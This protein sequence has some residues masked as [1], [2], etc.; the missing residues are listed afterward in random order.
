VFFYQW[1]IS[2]RILHVKH[3]RAR[4]CIPFTWLTGCF[5][6][7]IN[8]PTFFLTEMASQY[9]STQPI[10]NISMTIHPQMALKR[11]R[12]CAITRLEKIRNRRE[13]L[14]PASR[15]FLLWFILR[16]CR[17]RRHVPP[18]CRLTS[19]GLLGIVSR[20]MKFFLSPYSLSLTWIWTGTLRM[21]ARPFTALVIW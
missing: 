20:K 16:P 6:L 8:R 1:S 17:W 9:K 12:Q 21:G 7:K 5:P 11:L 10:K 13:I 14:S 15:R 3:I 4:S 19:N 2:A 18:K